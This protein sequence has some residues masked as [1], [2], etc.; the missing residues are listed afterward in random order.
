MVYFSYCFV[1]VGVGHSERVGL[2][3]SLNLQRVKAKILKCWD[4]LNIFL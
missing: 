2:A 3:R 1:F 4:L